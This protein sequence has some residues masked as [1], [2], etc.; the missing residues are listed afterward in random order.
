MNAQAQTGATH[1]LASPDYLR[2]AAMNLKEL[3][4]TWL[5][6]ER[7]D[8]AALAGWEFRGLN[9]G[10]KYHALLPFQKFIKGFYATT[11]AIQPDSG[12][13]MGGVRGYNIPVRQ[14]GPHAAWTAKP[15]DHDPKRFGFFGVNRVDP[16][17]RD[18]RHLRALLL[19]YGAAPNPLLDITKGLRDYVV[20]VHPGSDE[21]LIGKAWYAL[22]L[23]RVPV[24]FFILER[25]RATSFVGP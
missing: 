22:G 7:P 12:R 19:D 15:R 10:T 18:N 25:H 24:G 2:L 14:D 23:V 11:H 13:A 17:S 9:V 6:G 16:E 1:S 3:D 21:L 4:A 5:R 20:R 8:A